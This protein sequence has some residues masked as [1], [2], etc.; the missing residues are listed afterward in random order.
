MTANRP[1][2]LVVDDEPSIAD[3][4]AARLSEQYDVQTAYRGADALEALDEEVDAVLLDR[5][6]PGLSGDEVLE[7]I[8]RRNL[9]CRVAMATA[10]EPE[11]DIVEMGFDGYL[12]KPV[13]RE[14]LFETVETLVRR[15]EYDTQLQEFF[16]LASK[17][18]VLRTEHD[19]AT[20]AEHDEFDELTDRLEQLR[21]ELDDLLAELP[22]EEG[23]SIA[24]DGNVTVE[25]PFEA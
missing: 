6:M 1:T 13:S 22:P 24:A 10:V 8:R 4:H 2:V 16:S 14:A 7:E 12:V 15:V 21:A 9:P 18:A 19:E 20:L 11:F 5:R 23:Y 3:G 25:D 17:V